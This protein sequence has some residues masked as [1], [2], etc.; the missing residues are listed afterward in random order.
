MISVLNKVL[1]YVYG[2]LFKTIGTAKKYDFNNKRAG[3]KLY[4]ISSSYIQYYCLN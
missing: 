4:N 2:L 3:Y 1:V